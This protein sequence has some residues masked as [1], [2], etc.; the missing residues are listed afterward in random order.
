[1]DGSLFAEL[2]KDKKHRQRTI[3]VLC[4]V[5][6]CVA[7]LLFWQMHKTGVAMTDRTICGMPEHTHDENCIADRIVICGD[8]DHVHT[9]DCYRTVWSCGMEEHS[10]TS[11]C[12]PDHTADVES[13]ETWEASLP[14]LS[15]YPISDIV[16]IAESQI[17]YAE[18][19]RNVE[20]T[21]LGDGDYASRGYTRYGAFADDPYCDNWSAAFVSFCLQYSGLTESAAPRHTDC[22]AMQQL[23]EDAGAFAQPDAHNAQPGDIV[24]VDSD[25]DGTADRVGIVSFSNAQ[26]IR[27][28]EGN[29]NEQ[30][31][32]NEIPFSDGTILGYGVPS[33]VIE[34]PD[35][36]TE[37]ETETATET[38]TETKTEPSPSD[39]GTTY[40]VSGSTSGSSW[41]T[42]STRKAAPKK[43]AKR[44]A[45]AQ[46]RSTPSADVPLDDYISGVTATGTVKIDETHYLTMLELSFNLDPESALTVTESG[47]KFYFDL[48]EEVS[49][50]DDLVEGGPYAAYKI[51]SSPLELA[52]TYSFVPNGD[53]TFR[54]EIEFNDHYV[55]DAVVSGSDYIYNALRFK[56]YINVEEGETGNG[57]DISFTADQELHIPA[58]EINENYDIS[59]RKTGSFTSDGKL[60]YEVTVSSING[61]PSTVDIADTFTYSGE[62]TISAPTSISVVQHHADGTI[63]TFS[64]PAQGHITSTVP[65]VFDMDVSLPQLDDNEYYTLTYDYAVTGLT[66]VESAVSAYN[67]IEATSS[68]EHESTMDSTDYFIYNQQ[69]KKVGKDGIPF[70]DYIQWHITVNERGGDVAGKVLYDDGFMNERNETINGTNGIVVQKGWADATPGVDYEFVYNN[71]GDIIGIRFLP[72]D[73]STPN[74]NLYHITYYTYPDVAYGE[75]TV[76]HNEAEF[77]GDTA[78]YDVV[79]TGGDI[80]KTAD[81][82]QS[83]TSDL[84]TMN[85][86]VMVDVPVDGIQAGTTFTDTLSPAGHYMTQAQYNALVTAL[87]TAWGASN[88]TISPIYTADKITGYTFTVGTAGNPNLLHDGFIDNIYWQYQTTGEMD[89]KP[90]ETF[91]NTITD[92]TK[93][94]PVSNTISPHV[95]KLNVRKITNWYVTFSEEP[96]SL[97]FDYEDEDKMFVWV[98]EVT[99]TSD[100]MQYRVIDT[101]PEGVEL[102]AI[103]VIKSPLAAYN[104]GID[105][106]PD[107]L[108][109]IN[110]DGTISGEIGQL[111]LNKTTA[112]GSVTTDANG[113]QVV[114][115]LLSRNS[116]AADLL[117]STFNVIYFCQLS[118]DAWPTN[119]TVHL[120][121]D[122]TVDVIAGN[123]EYGE[124]ENE[125][126]ID[127][128]NT[129]DVVGKSGRWNSETH[130]ITYTVDINPGA[131]N[132]LTSSGGT[133]DPEWLTFTDVLTYTAR[134][135]TGTGEAVLNLNSV[136]LEKEENGVW[137]TLNNI[138]WT[139]HT[140]VDP[141]NPNAKQAIIEMRIPD[142]EHLRLTYSYHV[143]SSM[144]DGI[145][146]EN[147]A[148]VEGHGDESGDNNTHIGVEDFQTSGESSYKEF[149]LIKIDEEDGRPLSGA[150]FTVFSW[151]AQNHEWVATAKTYTTDQDGKII[152]KV[153][154]RYE[155][156]TNIYSKDTAYCIMETAAPVGYILPDNPRP[157]YFWFSEHA[158]A[159]AE[160]PDDFM[161]SA[162]DVSTSSH[163]IEAENQCE[164][165]YVTETGIYGM[166]LLPSLVCLLTA[167]I[168]AFL[169]AWKVIR[170]KRFGAEA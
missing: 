134:Q 9:D 70:G 2:N 73:G 80:E 12:Y 64:I 57:L 144:S 32:E 124:A 6:V 13:P 116:T 105:T 99:P 123:D 47:Y 63:E 153:T 152:I 142:N 41:I 10:H 111:W 157:F 24:F 170:K 162:A 139:A 91:T 59:T 115:L 48:P 33:V 133:L 130:L 14:V 138:Q 87:E 137:T 68:D 149:R 23:W 36:D 155:D 40:R 69:R 167:G 135:G 96:Q 159:P 53:G 117:S 164:E 112:S 56:C 77:D 34:T 39:E 20:F 4:L 122:N 72:A 169:I 166:K 62:G 156:D 50:L 25:A 58:D 74:N 94:L 7:L 101:L 83:V 136:V 100:L 90:T 55:E 66:S 93:T 29:S 38:E 126:I 145:T 15:G 128:T 67:T 35:Q 120:T 54:I 71:D 125:I 151:D 79:M 118:E 27:V 114:D 75:T 110:S 161:L 106:F 113:R 52:F 31:E 49:V 165:D 42:R 141:T 30:V 22:G 18:S 1:M 46:I 119:G 81:G 78:S 17:G 147:S 163:R 154:D 86:T 5:L 158:L 102:L 97:A 168:G 140:D 37:A 95:K 28:I 85:W 109:T 19:T 103:K 104:Y 148:T 160:G 60:H 89:G 108:V 44:A 143:N 121:L 146:L 127:A 132:L 84:H 82:E 131:E 76:E 26:Y 129:Q 11:A 88:V 21:E 92:G 8:D 107:N 61:T 150:E 16:R 43:A 45:P 65:N 51:D 98:V 3:A